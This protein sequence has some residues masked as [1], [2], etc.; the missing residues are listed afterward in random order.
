MSAVV[1]GGVANGL[2]IPSIR[3]DAET[4]M[5]GRP[6]HVKP[7]AS[8]KQKA[9]EVA[10]ETDVYT[11][12][13]LSLADQKGDDGPVTYNIFGILTVEGMPLQEAFEHLI[14]GFVQNTAR[15]LQD[16]MHSTIH[17]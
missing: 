11:V 16:E 12:H 7:L 6:D 2:F 14:T 15:D 8:S 9:A 1:V 5:L 3:M 10:R 4:V 17:H 13:P